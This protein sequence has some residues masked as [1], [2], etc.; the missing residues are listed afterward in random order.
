M[1]PLFRGFLFF[2]VAV[3]SALAQFE[4]AVV[5]GTVRDATQS[6]VPDA[7]I[8]LLNIETGIQAT[9]QTD[10]NGGYLF[11]NVKIG[12]YKVTA[13]KAGFSTTFADNV[14]VDVNARQ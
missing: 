10:D 2:F 5:L 11:N 12:R 7:K 9:A 3:A 1:K 13:E 14:K 6:A 4:T 8:T